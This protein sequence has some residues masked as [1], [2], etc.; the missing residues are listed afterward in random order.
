MVGGFAEMPGLHR[1]ALAVE[2]CERGVDECLGLFDLRHMAGV[3]QRQR[4]RVR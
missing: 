1:S 4:A 3:W 2:K